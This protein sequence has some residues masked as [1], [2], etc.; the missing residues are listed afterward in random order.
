MKTVQVGLIGFGTVGRG[1]YNLIRKN[2]DIIMNR[3]GISI[4]IKTIC[5]LDIDKVKLETIGAAVTHDWKDIIDDPEID[6]VLELIG[7]IEPAK[8]IILSALDKEKSVV[9]ANKKLL[10]EHGRDLL[11]ESVKDISKLRFEAAVAGGIP[12]ILALKEGLVGNRVNSIMGILNGTTNYILTKMADS[13]IAFPDALR[14]AQEKGFAEADPTFDVEG[15]DAGH[16]ISILAML[17]FNR[18]IDYKSIYIEI[19]RAHV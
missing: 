13:G 3:T 2:H 18:L 1:V 14:R 11:G 8:T 4:E 7:G 19:G 6:V 12:C 17:A 16:K 9:T 5:D 15:F 10:A